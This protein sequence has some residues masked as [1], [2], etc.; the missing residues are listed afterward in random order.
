M[1]ALA[2]LF[3]LAS[4]TRIDSTAVTARSTAVTRPSVPESMRDHAAHR[5]VAVDLAARRLWYV[6]GDSVRFT[7]P[8]AV[9]MGTPREPGARGGRFATPRGV[10][11]VTRR[12]VN[13]LWVPPDWHFAEQARKTGRPLRQLRTRDTLVAGDGS[14][15]FVRGATVVRLASDGRTTPLP[16]AT[17]R[18]LVI[19][20]AIVVPPIGTEQRRY[21][22]VL[23]THRLV[24]EGAYGI[25]GTTD[26][27]S[28]GRAASHGCIRLRNADVAVL[29][30]LVAE[31]TP[32]LLF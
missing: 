31:G 16:G 18:E 10:M 22:K 29:H 28:I 25:H 9:G 11:I 32:V 20:G 7:A 14:R 2:L 21:P 27:G 4:A 30:A 1:L 13:P 19:D 17:G 5:Y 3:S 8:V 12:E 24:L 23:G 26:P 15:Y 6:E